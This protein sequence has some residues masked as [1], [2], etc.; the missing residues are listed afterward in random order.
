MLTLLIAFLVFG[1]FATGYFMGKAHGY[2]EGFHDGENHEQKYREFLLEGKEKK[3]GRPRKVVEE[4][5]ENN[6]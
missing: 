3:R 2:S 6:I 4:H 1:I 5:L